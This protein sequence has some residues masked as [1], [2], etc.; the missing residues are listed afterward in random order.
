[1]E[2]CCETNEFDYQVLPFLRRMSNLEELTLKISNEDRTSVVDGIVIHNQI[3][4]HLARLHKFNFHIRT[5]TYLNYVEH[6][7]SNDDIQQ[8]FMNIGYQHVRCILY[9]IDRRVVCHVFS[10]P[11]M[12]DRL[13]YI[14]NR[15]P[16]IVFTHVTKLMVYDRFPFKHE[17]FI[18]LAQFFPFLKDLLI[19]NDKGQSYKSG[20]VNSDLNQLYSV[21]EY[22]YLD[23]LCVYDCYIDYVEQFLNETKTRLP[24]LRKLTVM[25]SV[26]IMVTKHFTRDTTRLNCAKV[27]Q[28]II[29]TPVNHLKR[30]YTY[31]PSLEYC[32]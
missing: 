30:F 11:F 19:R 14:G 16:P 8:T 3:L 21:V 26:L 27:K 25:Y 17:F 1:L 6:R 20:N 9:Y 10:L 2:Y 31:F 5:S 28:L 22:P 4:V 12:F 13:D 23:S 7:L 32:S 24:R 18:R 29:K 15:F